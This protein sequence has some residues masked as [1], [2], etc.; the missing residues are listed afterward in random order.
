VFGCKPVPALKLATSSELYRRM[1]EDMDVDCGAVLE[2]RSIEEMG[3][4]IFEE[5]IAVASGKKTKS[6][7]LGM[8]D[9]EFHPWLAG[10]TL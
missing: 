7:L 5:L 6:E 3:R 4:A 8:G 9:E 2:G 10:P 1:E